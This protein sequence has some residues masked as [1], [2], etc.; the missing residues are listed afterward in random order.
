MSNS[1]TGSGWS[2]NIVR[3]TT[4]WYCLWSFPSWYH[5]GNAYNR[6]STFFSR[7][8]C[9][10]GYKICETS[11]FNGTK[12]F[13]LEIPFDDP[14]VEKEYV[15]KNETNYTLHVNDTLYVGPEMKLYHHPVGIECIRA[16]VEPP[17][18]AGYC[19][20]DNQYWAVS[21]SNLYPQWGLYVGNKPLN[22]ATALSNGYR[23][24]MNA[25]HLLMQVPLFAIGI[26]DKKFHP[27]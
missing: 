15:N 16:N 20:K 9:E 4:I 22:E 1:L 26:I 10:Q 25:T 2:I 21:I 8:S 19:D 5:S 3:D 11:S 6:W 14:I 23:I 7:G 12:C 17:Q 24:S 13:N 18:S 27:K